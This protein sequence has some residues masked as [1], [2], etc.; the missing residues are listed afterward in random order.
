VASARR[1]RA[2]DLLDGGAERERETPA[3]VAGAKVFDLM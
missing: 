2:K 3:N 1:R